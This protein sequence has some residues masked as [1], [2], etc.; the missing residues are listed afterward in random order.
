VRPAA[1]GR[2]RRSPPVGR[3]S[4]PTAPR[5]DLPTPRGSGP[6]GASVPS[7][8]HSGQPVVLAERPRC[9]DVGRPVEEEPVDRAGVA[10]AVAGAGGRVGASGVADPA[11]RC[12]V[13]PRSGRVRQGR[14]CGGCERPGWG[15]AAAA[16]SRLRDGWPARGSVRSASRRRRGVR[17]GAGPAWC[18]HAG[19]VRPAYAR[20]WCRWVVRGPASCGRGCGVRPTTRIGPYP[21]GAGPACSLR[22]AWSVPHGVQALRRGAGL[23]AWR[24]APRRRGRVR[25]A[26]L[27]RSFGAGPTLLC[28]RRR[29][30]PGRPR[31]PWLPGSR[32]RLLHGQPHA[33]GRVRRAV[34][35]FPV[36]RGVGS[37]PRCARTD[38]LAH[39]RRERRSR[40]PA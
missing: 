40:A 32:C 5:V 34:L 15:A 24:G 22:T 29:A 10:S 2:R 25:A 27:H 30:P 20:T 35:P 39:V 18:G 37:A 28:A 23:A 1:P 31:A 26:G 38:G 36:V 12:V 7:S 11:A 21:G 9:S 16:V 8:A 19:A 17:G 3:A 33:R 4:R 6:S 14:R 13:G